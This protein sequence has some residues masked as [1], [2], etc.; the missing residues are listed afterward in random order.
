[1]RARMVVELERLR[2]VYGEVEHAEAG[3]EDWFKILSYP[4][5]ESWLVGG[6]RRRAVSIV[7]SIKADY[8]GASP[9]GFLAPA[10]LNFEGAPPE[11]TG[12]PP[13]TV[14]FEGDWVFFSWHC[15]DWP[16]GDESDLNPNLVSW[17]PSFANRL[18]EGA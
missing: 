15:E 11:N 12:D 16:A 9:Y 17:S 14:P 7:F 4:L 2:E 1:M 5:P 18:R 8:P 10:G 6:D 13:G 3:G